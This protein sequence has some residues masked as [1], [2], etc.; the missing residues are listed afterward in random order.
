MQLTEAFPNWAFR[1]FLLTNLAKESGIFRWKPNLCPLRSSLPDLSR[2]PLSS[3]ESY[4]GVVTFVN[5]GKSSYVRLEDEDSIIRH[6]PK[7]RIK[8]LPE[9]GHFVHAEDKA[10]FLSALRGT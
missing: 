5:G 2:N 3:Q 6:F 7:A 10:G 8:V 9:A 4:G 1:K